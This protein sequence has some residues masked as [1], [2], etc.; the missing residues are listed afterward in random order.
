MFVFIDVHKGGLVM[1]KDQGLLAHASHWKEFLWY[2]LYVYNVI[3][4][5]CNV[6][7]LISY[8]KKEVFLISTC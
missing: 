5:T 6:G 2:V 7:S 8:L 3:G 1:D 4:F